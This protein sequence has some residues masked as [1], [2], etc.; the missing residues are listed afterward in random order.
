M[1]SKKPYIQDAVCENTNRVI[2]EEIGSRPA[3][4]K[5]VT[6]PPNPPTDAPT[7]EPTEEPFEPTEPTTTGTTVEPTTI[8]P[9][10]VIGLDGVMS[11]VFKAF[12]GKTAYVDS[13]LCSGDNAADHPEIAEHFNGSCPQKTNNVHKEAFQHQVFYTEGDFSGSRIP[14]GQF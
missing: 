3:T 13:L 14:T 12:G 11:G 8:D 1:P 5:P 9:S 2:C 6:S 4:E 10:N 7:E